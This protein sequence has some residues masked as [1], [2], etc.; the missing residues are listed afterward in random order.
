MAKPIKITPTL[1]GES[2]HAFNESIKNVTSE[3][4]D[5]II[6]MKKNFEKIKA[7]ADKK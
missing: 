4:L 5:T 1:H 2:A 3:S 6:R 7:L